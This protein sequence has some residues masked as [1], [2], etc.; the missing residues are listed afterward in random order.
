[1]HAKYVAGGHSSARG[2]W[3]GVL[4]RV[5]GPVDSKSIMFC[6]DI[7]YSVLA[8]GLGLHVQ[9]VDRVEAC[10]QLNS[11]QLNQVLFFFFCSDYTAESSSIFILISIYADIQSLHIK[12]KKKFKK[13]KCHIIWMS[14]RCQKIFVAHRVVDVWNSSDE[15][16][17]HV[18]H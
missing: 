14:F 18:I 12:M 6:Y 15:T 2:G 4:R 1:V 8:S 11:S 13:K 3:V 16:L 5:V 10:V 17:L 7:A 9:V